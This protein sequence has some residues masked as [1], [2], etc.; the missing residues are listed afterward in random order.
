VKLQKLVRDLQRQERGDGLFERIIPEVSHCSSNEGRD[1]R[2]EKN[3]RGG[4]DAIEPW[5]VFIGED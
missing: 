3:V 2:L 4:D 1:R 5:T